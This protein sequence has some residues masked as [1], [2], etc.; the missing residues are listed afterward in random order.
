MHFAEFLNR[1][2]PD[3]LA[4]LLP[5]TCVGLRYGHSQF[6]PTKLFSAVQTHRLVALAAP[7]TT[8][9][10][11]RIY[12]W[13]SSSHGLAPPMSTGEA[14]L[15]PGVTP[16]VHVRGIGMLTDCPSPTARALGLGPT[17]PTR[18][19]LASEPSDLRRRRF[20]RRFRYSSQHSHFHSLHTSSPSCFLA[21][22]TL[23]YHSILSDKSVV[24]VSRLSPVIFS[25]QEHLTSELLRTL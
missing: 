15:S 13:L 4:I 18:I 6:N 24:S 3:R 21:H 23:L 7:P 10:K 1:G 17:N 5:S 25:A 12:L 2:S 22:G 20:S 14:R 19:T 9:L 11:P 8:P 16:S